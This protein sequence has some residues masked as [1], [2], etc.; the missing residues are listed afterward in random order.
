MMTA[1]MRRTAE[2]APRLNSSSSLM[3]LKKKPNAYVWKPERS[4]EDVTAIPT[5]YQPWKMR[6][7]WD[8]AV[9]VSDTRGS[10]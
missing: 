4:M 1:R 3:G 9:T 5:M 10:G 8:G 2:V 6:G 7:W